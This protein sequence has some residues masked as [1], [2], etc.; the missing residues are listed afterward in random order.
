MA[1]ANL[2]NVPGTP[3]ELAVWSTAHARHHTDINRTIFELT[4]IVLP[5]FL[6]DPFDPADSSSMDQWLY[7]HQL[8]HDDI[9]QLLGISGFNLN[10]VD[11]QNPDE[12]AAWV[13][14][15]FN[16]HYQIANLLQVG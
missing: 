11:F 9:E 10:S 2:L 12:L 14:L 16:T 6:L 3:E 13:T 5:E 8:I 4:T 1:L 15:N 7:K